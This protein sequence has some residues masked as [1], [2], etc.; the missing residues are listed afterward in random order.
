[1]LDATPR[2]APFTPTTVTPP[3]QALGTFASMAALIRNPLEAWHEELFE[4][5]SR[6]LD[7]LGSDYLQV[8]DPALMQSVLLDDIDSFRKSPV[9]QRVV[10]PGVGD[11]LLVV[12]GEAWR[13][14]RR[15]AAPAF[16][17]DAMLALAPAMAAAG[18]RAADRLLA[19]ASPG[20]SV[21]V[22]PEMTRATFDVIAATLLGGDDPSFDQEAVARAVTGY[23]E[24]IGAVNLFDLLGVPDWIP[25]PGRGPGRRAIATLR[26][27]ADAALARRRARHQ[28]GGDLGDGFGEDLLGRMLAARDPETGRGLS[29]IELRDNIVTFIGAGH[30]TTALAL[31]WSLY[32][33]AGDQGVQDRLAAEARAVAGEG[34]IGPGQ[35]ERL[36]LHEQVIKE[37]MRLYPPAVMLQRQAIRPVRV[38]EHQLEPGTEVMCLIYVMHR[39]R[40]LWERPDGFDPDRFAPER[41]EGRHRFAHMPFGA[42]PRICIGMRFAYLEAVAI[43][44]AVMRKA[45]VALAPGHAALPRMRVTLRPDGGMPLLVTAR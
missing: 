44:A 8:M 29:D 20:R 7:W 23:V 31:T 26:G 16:R 45:R 22:L 17:H 19:A 33:L 36:V 1:M 32:L 10:R 11:G 43:L 5:P 37:A 41:S 18:E 21:D 39:S 3:R 35:V 15:A 14:Q 24:T 4:L 13:F 28:H 2:P 25:R 9:Q 6:R 12:E 34:P 38:G 27:A 42:G 30:E 40:L